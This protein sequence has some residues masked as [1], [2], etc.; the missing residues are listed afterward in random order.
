[1][2]RTILGKILNPDGGTGGARFGDEARK[3]R[4]NGRQPGATRARESVVHR[5]RPI[6]EEE[7]V[8]GHGLGLERLRVA[9]VAL[10][11]SA[12]AVSTLLSAPPVSSG[13]DSAA[14]RATVPVRPVV[15]PLHAPMPEQRMAQSAARFL[16][17]IT[18]PRASF[19]VRGIQCTSDETDTRMAG[20]GL[21]RQVRPVQIITWQAIS[22]SDQFA[23]GKSP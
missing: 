6:D 14:G 12:C 21:G 19:P 1:M 7:H 23:S 11:M 13:C 3:S 18:A 5:P 16:R 9:D 8:Y 10:V 20:S 2:G 17:V 22:A 15:V 4:L